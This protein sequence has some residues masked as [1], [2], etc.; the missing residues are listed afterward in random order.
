MQAY[1]SLPKQDLLL[2]LNKSFSPV[3]ISEAKSDLKKVIPVF[4]TELANERVVKN[5]LLTNK[6]APN[7]T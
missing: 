5:K 4:H 3:D 7:K 2:T 6:M 1:K